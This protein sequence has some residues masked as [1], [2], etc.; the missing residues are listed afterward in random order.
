MRIFK[1]ELC[2]FKVMQN[3]LGSVPKINQRIEPRNVST[4]FSTQFLSME[5]VRKDI[6]CEWERLGWVK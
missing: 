6:S 1:S 4:Y 3:I 5:F 2:I